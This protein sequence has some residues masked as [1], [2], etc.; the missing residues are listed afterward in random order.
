MLDSEL[1][2]KVVLTLH[3]QGKA[4]DNVGLAAEHLQYNH[5]SVSVLLTKL[6]LLTGFSSCE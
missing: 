3:L 2:S 5:P 1:V 6:F 4:R